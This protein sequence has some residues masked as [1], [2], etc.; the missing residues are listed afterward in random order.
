MSFHS[1]V[2]PRRFGAN[3]PRVDV[4]RANKPEPVLCPDCNT[5]FIG[6]DSFVRH[7][8]RFHP[9]TKINLTGAGG[10]ESHE[11]HGYQNQE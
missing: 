5:Y 1:N 9:P 11:A 8:E 3:A 6:R 4:A 2:M 7:R 10:I